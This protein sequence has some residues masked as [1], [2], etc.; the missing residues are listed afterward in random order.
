MPAIVGPILLRQG[1]YAFDLWTPEEGLSRGYGYRRVGDAHYARNAE[2][3]SR[4]RQPDA[5]VVCATLE[6]FTT[7]VAEREATYRSLVSGLRSQSVGSDRKM[8]R[9]IRELMEPVV[10]AV[11]T[12]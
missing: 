11:I 2:I 12:Q 10:A 9:T 3:K 7:A 1:C 4:A 5:I 6:E 8:E